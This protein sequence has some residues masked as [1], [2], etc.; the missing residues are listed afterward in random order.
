M[1][2]VQQMYAKHI[3]ITILMLIYCIINIANTI[4]WA[5]LENENAEHGRGKKKECLCRKSNFQKCEK[6]T[7]YTG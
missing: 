1:N 2:A 6:P 3:G 7:I 5:Y 4:H